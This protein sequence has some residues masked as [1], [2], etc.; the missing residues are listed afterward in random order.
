MFLGE[1]LP[2]LNLRCPR[3]IKFL[4]GGF[5]MSLR[6]YKNNIPI[7]MYHSISISGNA[8]FKQFT[9][10]PAVFAQQMAY[11]HDAGYTPLTVSQFVQARTRPI[12]LPAR[13]VVLTFDDGFADF[14]TAA[15]PV[16]QHYHFV[17]TLY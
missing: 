2:P 4:R 9:V 6:D 15:L 1:G 8:K 17:A 11:L 13:P 16:L 3:I 10:S 7:L 12:D 14:F 5:S